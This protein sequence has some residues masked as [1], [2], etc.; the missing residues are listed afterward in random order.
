M[1]NKGGLCQ[2]DRTKELEPRLRLRD[3][4]PLVLVLS[5][6]RRCRVSV[7]VLRLTLNI[8]VRG[9]DVRRNELAIDQIFHADRRLKDSRFDCHI[10][11]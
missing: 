10:V 8:D 7:A 11:Y 5:I 6:S 9:L 2:R 1:R 4:V 3:L